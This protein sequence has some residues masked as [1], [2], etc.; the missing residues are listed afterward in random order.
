MAF[1]LPELPYARD[2]LA[3]HISAET[4]DYHYGKHNQAYV[5][6]LNSLVA[7]TP[8]ADQDLETVVRESE[9]AVFNN[10]GQIWN[11]NLYWHCMSPDGGGE[12]T[13]QLAELIDRDFGDFATFK[14]QFTD[15][16]IN[17]FGSGWAWLVQKDDGT[18]AI[19]S[20]SNADNPLKHGQNALMGCDMWEHSYY[21]DY[22][23][24][25]PDYMAAFWHV[26]NWDFI[27]SRLK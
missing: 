3:P 17:T 8:H 4:L 19:T 26:V 21:I 22:R 20:T 11:H 10:A 25:R 18:L 14:K 23:N 1:S 2:A 9:G 7:G 5:D 16:A 27:A 6:K 24:S 13:G 12:P 15:A